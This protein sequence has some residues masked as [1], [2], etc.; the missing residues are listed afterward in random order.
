MD[1]TPIFDI[2]P[3]LP[4]TDSHPD[5]A[6][7]FA[8]GVYGKKLEVVFDVPDAS[9]P[10]GDTLETLREI[11]AEDP[12]P[13]YQDDPERVYGFAFDVY[14]IKFRVCGNVLTVNDITKTNGGTL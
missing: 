11:L 1:G 12:R 14:E 10:Q 8:G 13:S 6:S 2:K 9:L 7:G 5:A 3:Y 4:Y